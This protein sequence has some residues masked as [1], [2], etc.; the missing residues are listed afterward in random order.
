MKKH[1][2]IKGLIAPVFTPMN[3]EGDVDTK[4]IPRYAQDLKSK[5]LAGVFVSGSS[6]EGVL[7][8]TKERNFLSIC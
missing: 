6:G 3:D 1:S 5:G 7:L 8:T 4:V 2:K